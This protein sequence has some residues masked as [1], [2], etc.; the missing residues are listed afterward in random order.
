MAAA[1]DL[2]LQLKISEFCERCCVWKISDRHLRSPL[3]K[4][5]GVPQRSRCMRGVAF[6]LLFNGRF[7]HWRG[8]G[9]PMHARATAPGPGG[10]LALSRLGLAGHAASASRL[11]GC[12]VSPHS[13][14]QNPHTDTLSK[15]TH[16]TQLVS[17]HNPPHAQ[18]ERKRK[19]ACYCLFFRTSEVRLRYVLAV[20]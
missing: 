10:P 11:S 14:S 20:L 3:N 13:L 15:P 17:T 16:I 19:G 5:T 7:I 1:Q 4:S 18:S 6:S 9:A 2:Y 8:R 12:G